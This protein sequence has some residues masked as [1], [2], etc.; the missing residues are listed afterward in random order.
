MNN[1]IFRKTWCILI[2]VLSATFFSCNKKEEKKREIVKQEF[3]TVMPQKEFILDPQTYKDENSRALIVQLFEG[4]TELK[5]TGARIV[6]ADKIIHSDDFLSWE[7]ILRKD[8]VWSDGEK[9]T[10]KTFKD[11][12][13]EAAKNKEVNTD[14]YKL[15]VIKNVKAEKNILKIELKEPIKNFDEWLASPIFFPIRRENKNLSPTELIVNGAFKIKEYNKDK[16]ILEKNKSYW[17]NIN[18]RLKKVDISLV[19]DKIMAYEMF[20]RLEI[21]YIG[22][23]FYRIPYERRKQFKSH[24]ERVVFPVNRYSFVELNKNDKFLNDKEIKELMYR[25][26]DPEFMGNAII[27]NGSPSIFLH[28]HPVMSVREKAQEEFKGYSEKHGIDL[29]EK[30]FVANYDENNVFE[31]RYLLSTVKEWISNFKFPIRVTKNIV[32]NPAFKM[33][34][35]LIGSS[36]IYDFCYYINYFYGT[37]IKNEKEFLKILPVLP[38]NKVYNSALV[39]SNVNGLN[40]EQN[41]DLHLKYINMLHRSGD[42]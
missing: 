24:P 42:E 39:H 32:P 1:K 28:P 12:W 9:I 37:N 40:V 17:D 20:P 34:M 23:P 5:E 16:I 30:I 38:M 2:I 35:Y 36:D 26:S 18:T 33:K 27:Q 7:V 14:V 11:S 3:Y 21:D 10:A 31:K 41:G 25:V 8:L 4:I 13:N 6:S 19:E 29:S 15:S 22:A